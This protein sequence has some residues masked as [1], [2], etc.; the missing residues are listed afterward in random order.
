MNV[1]C[2]TCTTRALLIMKQ[3]GVLLP[4]PGWD[5]SPEH[6]KYLFIDSEV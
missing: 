5:V 2:I 6:I 3:Q 4:T 1:Y